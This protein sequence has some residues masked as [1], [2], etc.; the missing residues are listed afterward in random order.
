[1]FDDVKSVHML[2]KHVIKIKRAANT[3]VRYFQLESV[4]CPPPRKKT[5]SSRHKKKN[6]PED[7]EEQKICTESDGKC[8]LKALLEH[9]SG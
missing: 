4:T 9:L 1:M 3:S 6:A 8:F 7:T 2:K 5:K